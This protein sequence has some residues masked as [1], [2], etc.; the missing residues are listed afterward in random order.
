MNSRLDRFFHIGRRHRLDGR[1]P[2][3]EQQLGDGHIQLLGKRNQQSNIRTAQSP[4][5]LTDGFV[6][7]MES[8]GQLTLGETFSRRWAWRNA[9]NAS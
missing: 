2:P 5:P 8:L 3:A 7:N 6:G 1:A 9:P 4:L